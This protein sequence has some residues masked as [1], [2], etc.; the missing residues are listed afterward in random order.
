MYI[1]WQG[2]IQTVPERSQT[3][4]DHTLV[5]QKNKNENVNM[6]KS[7]SVKE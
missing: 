7:M 2:R 1:S 4:S 5:Q 6:R 3:K